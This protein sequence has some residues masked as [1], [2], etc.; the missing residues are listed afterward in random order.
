MKTLQNRLAGAAMA[1]ALGITAFL[2]VQ[3]AQAAADPAVTSPGAEVTAVTG[4]ATVFQNGDSVR[5]TRGMRVTKG[6]RIQTGLGTVTLNLGEHG[7]VTVES[8]SS[9]TID[10]LNQQKGKELTVF[11]LT[12]GGLIGDVK[13][14]TRESEYQVKTAKGVAGIR[15]T[16]YH[17]LAVGVFKCFDGSIFVALVAKGPDGQV[18]TVVVNAGKKI[19]A[20]AALVEQ[21]TDMTAAEL[22]EIVDSTKPGGFTVVDRTPEPFVSPT[23]GN[24]KDD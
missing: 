21:V 22:K 5:L 11:N 8:R 10:E 1:L 13:K 7:I 3:Q 4:R 20:T 9:V 18:Q 19:D 17:I 23:A 2:P 6:A 24:K 15:G 16:K 12:K 14:V